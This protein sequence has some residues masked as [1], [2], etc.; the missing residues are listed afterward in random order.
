MNI[1]KG[2]IQSAIYSMG[3]ESTSGRRIPVTNI[4]IP[5]TIERVG[6]LTNPFRLTFDLYP[7]DRPTKVRTSV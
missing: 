1:A 2:V 3:M 6:G 4:K 5:N 7:V